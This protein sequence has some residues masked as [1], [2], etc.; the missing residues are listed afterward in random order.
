MQM[1]TWDPDRDLNL[2]Q[3][4]VNRLF[5][6]FFADDHAPARARFV[7]PLDVL[8]QEEHFL[9][10]ADLPGIAEEDVTIEV[11][12]RTLRISGERKPE[13]ADR[14]AGVRRSERQ[15]GRFARTLTLPEGVD[16][17]AIAASFEHGVLELRVPKPEQR[18]PRRVRI[19]AGSARRDDQAVIEA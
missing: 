9:V 8:E 1:L 4:D 18:R 11:E 6:R 16:V 12:D 13:H 14:Q 7:P 2:L 19:G 5:D 10:L 3:G 15:W 17:D